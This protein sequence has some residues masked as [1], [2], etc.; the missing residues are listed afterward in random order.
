VNDLILKCGDERR[1]QLVRDQEL[2]G[3]DY[4]EVEE[5]QTVL[6]VHFIG[7]APESIPLKN[8]LIEGGRRVRGI[9]AIDVKV[10]HKDDPYADDCMKVTVDK[11][12]DFST[13]TLRLAELDAMGEPTGQPLEGFDPRYAQIDFSFKASCPSDLDC[14]RQSACPPEKLPE[15]EISY[16]AKDYASFRQLILD[17]LALIMP[18]WTERHIPDIN[19]A[20]VEILA[21]TGDYLSYYQDAVATEAY[22]GT[23]RQR[24]SVRRHVRLVD[25]LMHEG[26]NARAWVCMESDQDMILSAKDVYFITG[27]DAIPIGP[28]LSPD[29]L[30]K[31]S[32]GDYEVF[33]PLIPGK[34]PKKIDSWEIQGTESMILKLKEP[35]DPVSR[36]L[37][38]EIS[39]RTRKL[40]DDYII[41]G[42]PGAHLA[43]PQASSI[44]D[45]KTILVEDLN[46]L[47]RA[48]IISR[49]TLEDAYPVEIEGSQKIQIY[50]NHSKIYFYTW[51]D[52]ECCLLKGATSATLF[53]G[54][55]PAK[56]ESES[57]SQ[58]QRGVK[59]GQ[60]E[61]SPEP[62][63]E[64][65]R[66]LNLKKG[67][68]LIFEE[69]VGPKT[70]NKADASSAHRYAVRLTK[71]PQ[72]GIDP[73]KQKVSGYE[74][75][76]NALVLEIE[77]D[78]GDALP[79]PLC[80]ST[81]SQDCDLI[82]NVS[83]A[84]GNVVLVDHGMTLAPEPLGSVPPGDISKIC[85]CN[86]LVSEVAGSPSKFNPGLK[87]H[88]LTFSR[89]LVDSAPASGML[90]AV[91]CDE[92]DSAC[93]LAMPQLRLV[94]MPPRCQRTAMEWFARSDLLSSQ[95]QDQDFVVEIDDDGTPYL[96]FG[97]GDLGKMPASGTEF[98]AIYRVGN[99]TSGNIGSE[100][101]SKVVFRR[102]KED[103][104]TSVRNPLPA[105]GGTDPEST[106]EVKLL[107]PGA[108]RKDLQRAVTADDYARL[109]ECDPRVQRAAAVLVWTGSWYEALVAVDQLGKEEPDADLLDE[110]REHLE[111]SSRLGH[112]LKIVPAVHVPLDITISICVKP[113]YQKGHVE[114]ALLD[115][116][117]D[118]AIPDGSLG[119]FHPDNL[120]FG[121]SIYLSKIVAAAQAVDGVEMVM[122]K[123]LERHGTGPNHEIENGL[124]QLGPL[125][126][127]QVD[128]DPNFPENGQF[129]IEI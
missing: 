64:P 90:F 88:P 110:I 99:G 106:D 13:Y 26:C 89:P 23:A 107:A 127:A 114:A 109:A 116:F 58:S 77:W 48:G 67:D 35:Q 119:F 6:N 28:V 1:R 83:V 85:D 65:E 102:G 96:R 19:L 111:G 18:D 92:H 123:K 43:L 72:K 129:L 57:L 63:P 39:A 62:E 20:L 4:L 70:G 81:L 56:S 50:K 93:A 100:A 118:R 74:G 73:L 31:I 53:D 41:P 87:E 126:I 51:G 12:G 121:D 32:S 69:V 14:K 45:L 124:L 27:S 37:R 103:G 60:K 34:V 29:D 21:Y 3:L 101:I 79:F 52:K 122:V 86:G 117:S 25:Y 42:V 40:I 128:N 17:R 66:L 7:K 46:Y 78:A 91:T 8:I 16:L 15:P 36:C 94:G 120:S 108:F 84:R 33:E 44:D 113:H 82:D 10:Q 98:L 38:E 112:D 71:E 95:G 59:R 9:K 22:L 55:A 5:Q 2:F 47:L 30:G 24:I 125:E 105:I 11:P 49:K 68:I 115:V 80:I 54:W 76:Q 104:I 61:T 75:D 97:D